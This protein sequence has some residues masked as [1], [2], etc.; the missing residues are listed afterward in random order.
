MAQ[1][2][3]HIQ[4][5]WRPATNREN[6]PSILQ[7]I[8][9]RLGEICHEIR[10]IAE[11]RHR[12][13]E[14]QTP[15]LGKSVIYFGEICHR[16]WGNPL[17]ILGKSVT[18]FREINHRLWE[19]RQP[20]L[21]KSVTDFGEIRHRLWENE[22]PTLGKSATDFGEIRHRLWENE[23]PALGKW[24]TDFGK[25]SHR[26]CGKIGSV[27]GKDLGKLVW[28]LDWLATKLKSHC[29]E[30]QACLGLDATKR[31][32]TG[33]KLEGQNVQAYRLWYRNCSGVR[34]RD[35]YEMPQAQADIHNSDWGQTYLNKY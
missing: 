11:I 31:K 30:R 22:P 20:T 29:F 7:K 16:V 14:K 15:N 2:N 23:P 18:E 12:F 25:M 3:P 21:G 13:W 1:I 17:P 19:N 5:S 10:R 8:S 24:A 6:L 9:R 28:F 4:V 32:P 26:L 34:V 27:L 35:L 33:G